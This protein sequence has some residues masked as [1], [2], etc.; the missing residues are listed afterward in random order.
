MSLGSDDITWEPGKKYIYTINFFT[1]GGGGGQIDPINPV[2]PGAP[3][4]SG[5]NFTVTVSD[6]VDGGSANLNMM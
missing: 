5:I 2:D 6:W 4:I 1:A 3:I